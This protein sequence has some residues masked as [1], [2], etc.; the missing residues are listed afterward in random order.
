M[1]PLKLPRVQ[2]ES[3]VECLF[4]VD[5]RTDRVSRSYPKKWDKALNCFNA[6]LKTVH[7]EYEEARS[8]HLISSDP[9]ISQTY[10]A[11]PPL[12]PDVVLRQIDL[13]R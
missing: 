11:Q 13:T 1:T 2:G 3:A 9:S 5:S 4:Q 12:V 6:R 8:R 10:I 7:M